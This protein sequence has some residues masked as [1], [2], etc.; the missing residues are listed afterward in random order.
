[1]SGGG[2]VSETLDRGALVWGAVFTL[3]GLTFLLQEAGVWEVRADVFLPALVIV[4]G[5]VLIASGL[6]RAGSEQ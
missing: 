2:A 3:V 4:A 5:V 1:V 6:L